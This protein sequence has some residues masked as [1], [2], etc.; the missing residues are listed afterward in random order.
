MD[1]IIE[2]YFIYLDIEGQPVRVTGAGQ[3]LYW[4]DEQWAGVGDLGS[5]GGLGEN[6]EMAA[7]QISLTIRGVPSEYIRTIKDLN[8][9]ERPV[10]VWQ[11]DLSSSYHVVNSQLIWSGRMDVIDIVAGSVSEMTLQCESAMARWNSSPGRRMNNT[12]QQLLHP[13][14][15]GL[16]YV[17]ACVNAVVSL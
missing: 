6:L 4:N 14:D 13:G 8:Y 3:P 11:N 16:K 15:N 1:D 2:V 7:A 10:H 9:Q 17:A 5:I 12:Q